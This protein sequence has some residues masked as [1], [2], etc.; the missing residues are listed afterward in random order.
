MAGGHER[1]GRE[2]KKPRREK[3]K[4][5]VAALPFASPRAKAV[6]PT[7]EPKK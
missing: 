3:P 4:A 5:T 7:P 1:S 6:T 2:A